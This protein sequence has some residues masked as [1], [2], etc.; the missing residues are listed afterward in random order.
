MIPFVSGE[1]KDLASV[2]IVKV[3]PLPVYPYEKIQT[4][5]PSINDWIIG[6]TSS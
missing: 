5:F 3:F 4:L 2:P 6:D 1:A